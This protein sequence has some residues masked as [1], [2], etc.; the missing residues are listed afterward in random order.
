MIPA[1]KQVAEEWNLKFFFRE[2]NYFVRKGQR[3]EMPLI[4]LRLAFP[5]TTK[6]IFTPRDFKVASRIIKNSLVKN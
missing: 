3:C 1:L 2:K 4:N 6:F 5:S